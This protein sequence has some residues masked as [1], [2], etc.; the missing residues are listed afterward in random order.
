MQETEI[1]SEV[2]NAARQQITSKAETKKKYGKNLLMQGIISIGILIGSLLLVIIVY[3]PM[4]GSIDV[5]KQKVVTVN[6]DIERLNKKYSV[7]NALTSEELNTK[8]TLVKTYIPDDI[9]V[10]ELATF[11]DTNSKRFNLSVTRIG[12]NEE[13]T[14]LASELSASKRTQYLSGVGNEKV[15]FGR[16]QGPFNFIGT[17]DNIFGFLD[18]LVSSGYA[19]HFDRVVLTRTESDMW[20]VSFTA[21]Y[22]YLSSVS[23]VPATRP[24]VTI[25]DDIIEY[26]NIT[27]T[28]TITATPQIY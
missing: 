12:I 14:D 1:S 5:T 7:I 3:V 10:A 17:K 18:F 11:V 13:R 24:L 9:K 15:T 6:S 8:L 2:V 4:L 16:V 22:Y 27:A 21:Q 23:K 26:R 19:T 28:P 25:Q 20:T